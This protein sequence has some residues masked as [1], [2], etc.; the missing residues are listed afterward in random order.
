VF[1]V[2]LNNFK[3]SSH[4]CQLEGVAPASTKKN[5]IETSTFTFTC[6]VLRHLASDVLCLQLPLA[7]LAAFLCTSTNACAMAMLPMLTHHLSGIP[8]SPAP[9]IRSAKHMQAE[10]FADLLCSSAGED[11]LP[12]LERMCKPAIT[13][14]THTALQPKDPHA[15]KRDGMMYVAVRTCNTHAHIRLRL[16]VS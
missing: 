4:R 12:T 11:W 16:S 15:Y 5:T 3:S 2:V 7:R 6:R 1:E 8:R 10:I 13:H 9:C 14:V